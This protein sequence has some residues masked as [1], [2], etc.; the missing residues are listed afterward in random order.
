MCKSVGVSAR[1]CDTYK[2]MIYVV[3]QLPVSILE[4]VVTE[5]RQSIQQFCPVFK[6]PGHYHSA[7]VNG[8]PFPKFPPL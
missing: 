4:K 2:L 3:L 7:S 8:Q 5:V 6:N 1:Q